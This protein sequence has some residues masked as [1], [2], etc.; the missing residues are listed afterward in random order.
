MVTRP[1]KAP[2]PECDA[3]HSGA[4]RVV[5]AFTKPFGSAPQNTMVIRPCVRSRSLVPRATENVTLGG[6]LGQTPSDHNPRC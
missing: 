5:V 2:P 6:R 3:D 4:Y 1:V